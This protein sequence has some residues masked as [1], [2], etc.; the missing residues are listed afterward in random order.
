MRKAKEGYNNK[1]DSK[2]LKFCGDSDSE[3]KTREAIE[4]LMK[5]KGKLL[6]W[7]IGSKVR[8][9]VKGRSLI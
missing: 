1:N 4:R 3:K 6:F 5:E 7:K 8:E 2:Y 9:K